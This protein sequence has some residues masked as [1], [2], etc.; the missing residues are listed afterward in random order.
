MP[1]EV[2]GTDG[3]VIRI[4]NGLGEGVRV[5]LNLPNTV[6]DDAKVNPS[7]PPGTPAPPPPAASGQPAAAQPAPVGSAQPK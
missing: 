6:P 7:V 4:L 3:R 2:A 1:I 5:A